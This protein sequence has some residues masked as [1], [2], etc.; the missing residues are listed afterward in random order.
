MSYVGTKCTCV[1][2][3]FLCPE[4]AFGQAER[5]EGWHSLEGSSLVRHSASLG[6]AEGGLSELPA[7]VSQEALLLGTGRNEKHP[8]N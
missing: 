3:S 7:S 1:S 8:L 4:E 6:P 5:G 2:V